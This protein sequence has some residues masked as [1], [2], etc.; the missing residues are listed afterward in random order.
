MRRLLGALDSKWIARP[1]TVYGLITLGATVVALVGFG[2]VALLYL[3]IWI[4]VAV[5]LVS[6]LM[7]SRQP[8]TVASPASH[9]V[10]SAGLPGSTK[11]LLTALARA[12]AADRT[13]IAEAAI[14]NPVNNQAAANELAQAFVELEAEVGTLIANAS[15]FDERWS[16][17]WTYRP[18]WAE[19]QPYGGRL[20]SREMLDELVR[21]MAW[22]GAQ[23]GAM[24]DF[25]ST[26]NDERVRHIRSWVK[27]AEERKREPETAA[28][29]EARG[30]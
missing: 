29:T 30:A 9:I 19:N 17:L 23:L 14:L 28:G 26:G 1:L 24:I 10:I 25:L 6:A 3:G 8:S 21:Y 4:V 18:G 20:F 16:L 5:A 22:R 7:F 12:E 27:A 11:A 13:Y 2:V 15:A